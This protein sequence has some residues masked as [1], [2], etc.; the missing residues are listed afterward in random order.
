[1][2]QLPRESAS[3]PRKNNIE[4]NA[5]SIE[6]SGGISPLVSLPYCVPRT[7]FSIEVAIN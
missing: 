2:Q 4:T 7:R 3:E 6:T 5:Q 1:L